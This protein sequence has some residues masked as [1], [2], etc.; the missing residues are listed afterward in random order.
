MTASS[1]SIWS[2]G[3]ES[4][5]AIDGDLRTAACTK[6]DKAD[7]WLLITLDQLY[8]VSFVRIY[9][10][11]EGNGSYNFYLKY[12]LLHNRDRV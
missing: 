3:Y 12:R 2:N 4:S 1:S 11:L 10:T 9:N 6:N 8:F 7:T 5:K